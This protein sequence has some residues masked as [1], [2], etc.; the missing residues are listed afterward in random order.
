MEELL[1]DLDFARWIEQLD[2]TDSAK[3]LDDF[4]DQF[5]VAWDRMVKLGIDGADKLAQ[6]AAKSLQ[7][8]RNSIL[9]IQET[10]AVRVRREAEAY[11]AQLQLIRAEQTARRAELMA[12]RAQL[13]ARSAFLQGYGETVRQQLQ[14]EGTLLKGRQATLQGTLEMLK[15]MDQAIEAIDLL[16][17]SLPDL[18]SNAEIDRAIRNAGRG[19][20]GGGPTQADRDA[21]MEATTGFGLTDFE[22]RMME[23][24]GFV[25]DHMAS[26]AELG[27][28]E[29]EL[30][31]IRRRATEEQQRMI[32]ELGREGLAALGS[33]SVATV[34]RLQ[35][36]G[37]H[38][39]FLRENADEL[40]LAL[41][42]VEAAAKELSQEITL[43][44]ASGLAQ[45]IDDAEVR[46]QL[47][48]L[49]HQLFMAQKNI[50]IQA[51]H[52][53]GLITHEQYKMLMDLLGLAKEWT[54][55]EVHDTADFSRTVRSDFASAR[56]DADRIRESFR[57][58]KDE[59]AGFLNDMLVGQYGGVSPVGGVDEA[60]RQLDEVLRQ[61]RTGN[62][63]AI[64]QFDDYA[65]TLLRLA[66]DAY[67]SS[68]EFQAIY[69]Y[70][71]ASGRDL[72]NVRTGREG[73]LV[74]DERFYSAQNQQV[75]LQRQTV[76]L[77]ERID[78]ALSR[79]PAGQRIAGAGVNR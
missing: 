72:L 16:L 51:A 49:E 39:K 23:A 79:Q 13:Q 40:G 65:G 14:L 46:R 53:M 21:A 18:I 61:A 11:N 9:G 19:A 7:D 34:Q 55:P 5:R 73:N 4:V 1:S 41:W 63:G 43:S 59:V 28:A 20:G 70:V 68:P 76:Q 74:F 58:A 78:R 35:D 45:Y 60:R 47:Q 71:L 3:K 10:A 12:E 75:D 64:E 8:Q 54:P 32:R 50:E 67:G 33:T 36:L 66:R 29:E 25:R 24:T 42:Q 52:T 26:V 56:D 22:R 31:E 37:L 62:I 17:G 30:A 57:R 48:I 69:D 2:L 6:W 15:A 77:L 27:F 38:L 44:I